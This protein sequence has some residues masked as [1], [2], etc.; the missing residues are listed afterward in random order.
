MD[1]FRAG[2][3]PEELLHN[4]LFFMNNLHLTV[5]EGIYLD[6][7]GESEADNISPED[8]DWLFKLWAFT[9]LNH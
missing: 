3:S 4:M 8:L 5:D 7:F 1:F 9:V 2:M 6:P